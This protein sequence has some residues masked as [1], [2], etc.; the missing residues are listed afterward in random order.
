MPA[1]ETSRPIYDCGRFY[2]ESA[3]YPEQLKFRKF[4][5]QWFKKLYDDEEELLV[6]ERELNVDIAELR[7]QD[8]QGPLTTLDFPRILSKRDGRLYGKWMRYENKL[9]AHAQDQCL[10][11]SLYQLPVHGSYAGATLNDNSELFKDGIF[12]P[13]NE[14]GGAAAYQDPASPEFIAVVD[15]GSYDF[16]MDLAVKNIGWIDQKILERLRRWF[17][18]SAGSGQIRLSTL[19]T[20]F[21][22]IACMFV[23]VLLTATMFALARISRLMVRIAVVG[24][25]GLIFTASAKLLSGLSRYSIFSLT[26]AY[27]AVA[28]VFVST[29]VDGAGK[30]T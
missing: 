28:S 4:G 19:R 30:T 3:E 29:A 11:N 22:I 6:M 9:R 26:A 8:G 10:V 24:V 14:S 12:C 1:Q 27:F 5:P 18:M 20:F 16:L 25:F 15:V 7:N 21:D 23:P 2:R 13:T 17:R